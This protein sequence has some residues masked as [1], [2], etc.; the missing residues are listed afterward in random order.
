MDI[1]I[2]N[3]IAL[4]VPHKAGGMPLMMALSRRH[5]TRLYTDRPLSP[6]LLSDLLWAACGINRPATGGRTA[7]SAR[8]WHAI[9]IYLAAADGAWRYEPEA[10]CL[11]RVLASDVR[12]STGMQEFVGTAALDLVY[13]ANLARM[14]ATDPL[15]RRFYCGADAGA[16]AQN[17]Y[18]FCAAE[19]LATVVRGLVDRRALA[20]ALGLGARQRVLLAQTVG[21]AA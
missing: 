12:A 10:H 15:E 18:L 17:V 19:G 6:Q 1:E 16:I 2:T 4:S 13:V 20:T 7:P 9:D 5:S 14:E 8:N 3:R 21:F 11:Q